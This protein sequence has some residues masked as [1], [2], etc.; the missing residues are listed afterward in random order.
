MYVM[1]FAVKVPEL[2]VAVCTCSGVQ[3]AYIES[4]FNTIWAVVQSLYDAPTLT[5]QE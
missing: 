5:C 1:R 4:V 3:T 2:C